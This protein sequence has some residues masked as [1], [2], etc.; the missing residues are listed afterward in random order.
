MGNQ[1]TGRRVGEAACVMGVNENQ[2]AVFSFLDTYFQH[3]GVRNP[4]HVAEGLHIDGL[5]G[6]KRGS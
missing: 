2:K 3:G 5:S 6:L 4:L 1:S